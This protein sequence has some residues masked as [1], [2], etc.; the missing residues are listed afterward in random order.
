MDGKTTATSMHVFCDVCGAAAGIVELQGRKMT[1]TDLRKQSAYVFQEDLYLPNA[2]VREAI[3]F[4]AFMKGVI[5][6]SESQHK[7]ACVISAVF[8]LIS[9][10]TKQTLW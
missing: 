3:S 8:G 1:T 6:R 5:T 2:T 9:D 7:R 10:Q 4:T